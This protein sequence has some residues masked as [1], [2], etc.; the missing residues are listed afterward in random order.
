MSKKRKTQTGYAVFPF[1]EFAELVC[2][3]PSES[4]KLMR[5]YAKENRLKEKNKNL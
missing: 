5:K 4:E 3:N 2:V 1:D